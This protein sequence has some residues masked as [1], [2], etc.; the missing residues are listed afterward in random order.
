LCFAVAN[1]AAS[2]SQTGQQAD[3]Q[4]LELGE[5]A[6]SLPLAGVEQG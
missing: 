1:V 3:Q 5:E 6:G 2:S 4:D